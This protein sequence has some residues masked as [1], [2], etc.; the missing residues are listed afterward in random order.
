MLYG[1]LLSLLIATCATA[2]QLLPFPPFTLHHNIHPLEPVMLSILLGI[3]INLFFTLP[4]QWRTGIVFSQKKILA[5]AII[6]LGSQLNIS[7][8]KTLSWQTILLMLGCISLTF[9]LTYAYAKIINTDRI[10]TTLVAIGTAVCGSSAIAAAAPSI[11]AKNHQVSVTITGINLLGLF[12]LLALPPLGRLLHL[13]NNQFG[14][15]CGTAIQAVPQVIAAGLSFSPAAGNIATLV[16]LVRI[17]FLAPFLMLARWCTPTENHTQH[18]FSRSQILPTFILGFFIV[19][20]LRT[21][22]LLPNI[23]LGMQRINTVAA[24][25]TTSHFLMC[26]ALAAIGLNTNLSDIKKSGT[27]TVVLTTISA[28][29]LLTI[30]YF[31]CHWI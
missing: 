31:V 17:C 1:I 20:L 11:N 22:N 15:W 24:L 6:L 8:I 3:G 7:T 16:K 29:T 23:S 30:S 18:K 13:S 25:G 19:M 2:S 27:N 12:A 5:L 28:L 4:E 14:F 9:L 26:V 10:T 21:L